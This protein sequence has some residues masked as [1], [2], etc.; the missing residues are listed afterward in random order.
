MK[1]LA[2]ETSTI[3]TVI[4]LGD[5]RRLLAGVTKRLEKGRGEKVP[6]MIAVCLK[7]AGLMF[8]DLD[9]FGVGV[10][11]GSFTGLRVGLSLVKGLSYALGKPIVAFS[12]LDA[13]AFN[14]KTEKGGRFAVVVDA[15]RSNVYYRFYDKGVALAPAAMVTAEGFLRKIS[16]KLFLSGDALLSYREAFSG[17]GKGVVVCPPKTWYPTPEGVAACVRR[18]WAAKKTTDSFGLQAVYFY[19]SD[20]QVNPV[21]NENSNGG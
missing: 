1:F 8:S 7:K 21:K 20:C 6:A 9:V 4:A 5:D 18:E 10:G 2:I 15:R 14:K 17:A 12:S 3:D 13:I 19:G 11:P 16:G